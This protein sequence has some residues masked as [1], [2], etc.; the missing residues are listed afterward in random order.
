LVYATPFVFAPSGIA[1]GYMNAQYRSHNKDVS[2]TLGLA[3]EGQMNST[4]NDLLPL[5]VRILLNMYRSDQKLR[6][7]TAFDKPV[8]MKSALEFPPIDIR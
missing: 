7:N 3:V 8:T 1:A 2:R 6:S 5:F 4:G